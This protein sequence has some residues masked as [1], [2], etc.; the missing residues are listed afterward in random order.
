M[1]KLLQF[2][3]KPHVTNYFGGC[4]ICGRTDG[5]KSVGR[6]HWYVCDEH[7]TKWCVGSNLFSVWRELTEAEHQRNYYLLATYR[8]VASLP[9]TKT[10][11]LEIDLS[12]AEPPF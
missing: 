7:K 2:P 10:R 4:P 12:E 1:G 5:C 3:T 8:E 9:M 11:N 6:D